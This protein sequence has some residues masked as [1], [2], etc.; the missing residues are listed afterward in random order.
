MNRLSVEA[1]EKYVEYVT[2]AVGH[3]RRIL[4]MYDKR[5]RS[6]GCEDGR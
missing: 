1:A 6:G 5:G 4:A 3:I 2:A